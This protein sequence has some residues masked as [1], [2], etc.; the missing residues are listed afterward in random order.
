M[1]ADHPWHFQDG[2]TVG[3][4]TSVFSENGLPLV[5]LEHPIFCKVRN[6]NVTAKIISSLF[7][8]VMYPMKSPGNQQVSATGVKPT[9]RRRP[10]GQPSH[11]AS[12]I[13][14]RT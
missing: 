9:A 8:L 5:P 6:P 2:G 7:E 4:G 10:P 1:A 3:T 11:L 14:I 13:R 12:Q